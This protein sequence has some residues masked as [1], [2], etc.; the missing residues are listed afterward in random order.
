[1]NTYQW[2]LIHG[3]PNYILL[4]L[5]FIPIVA[6][7]VNLLRYIVGTKSFGIYAPL[8]LTFAYIFTGIRIGLLITATVII[9]TLLAY[10][11]LKKIRMHYI[12]RITI[13]YIFTTIAIII[14]LAGIT[15]TN[16]STNVL[17]PLEAI[18][19]AGIILIATLSDFFV[20]QYI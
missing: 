1:M 2:L 9:A 14:L 8:T 7:I 4:L 20:K 3:I 15:F 12:S 17:P 10:S 13:V 5:I 6:T 19:P 16:L 11:L 18:P